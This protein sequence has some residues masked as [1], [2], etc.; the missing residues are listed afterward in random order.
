[1]ANRKL[2]L[3]LCGAAL[4]VLCFAAALWQVFRPAGAA[5]RSDKTLIRVAHWQLESGLRD[6]FDVIARDYE[7]LHPDVKIE[8]IAIPERIYP[9]WLRTQLVGG[10]APDLIQIGKG[11]DDEILARYFNPLSPY[12]KSANPYNEGTP[13]AD[14]PWRDTFIDGMTGSVTYQ[15]NLLD[16]YG[17]PLA[18]I[19][20]RIYYNVTAWRRILGD[21]PPP[22][23]YD[24]FVAA[25]ERIL[26]HAATTGENVI[27]LAGSNYGTPWF[28]SSLVGSQTQRLAQELDDSLVLQPISIET[29]LQYLSGRWSLEDPAFANG[30]RLAQQI[31]RYAQPGFLQAN[32]DDASFYFVQGRALMIVTGSWDAPSFRSLAPFEMSAFVMPLPQPS[33]PQYGA[34]VIGPVS[35]A[36]SPMGTSFGLTKTSRHPEV[37]MDFLRYITSF[38]GNAKFSAVSLWLPSVAEIPAPEPIKPFEPQLDGYVNGFGLAIGN[39]PDVRRVVESNLGTLFDPRAD[40]DKLQDTMAAKLP[41]ALRSD[42][43]RTVRSFLAN[44]NRQDTLVA[45]QS[46]LASR[47]PQNPDFARKRH[48]LLEAQTLQELRAA[49]IEHELAQSP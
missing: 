24:E 30:L 36:A 12:I 11:S 22:T 18:T 27:P 8:Q 2:I 35:E 13:L 10:T 48:E 5:D 39:G 45:A 28:A 25:C 32:R 20:T 40:I 7:R 42:L 46:V 21:T 41:D 16:Y 23:H 33:H 44:S 4:G 29:A 38:D 6:A 17:I 43:T 31:G 37:A 34:G 3:P 19:T 14:I 9:S 26:Q 47:H 49:W 1:M 15:P